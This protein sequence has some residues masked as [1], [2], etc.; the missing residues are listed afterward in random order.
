MWPSQPLARRW[1]RDICLKPML[2]DLWNRV[3]LAEL[4]TALPASVST[5]NWLFAIN[6]GLSGLFRFQVCISA[7]VLVQGQAP[8]LKRLKP[9]LHFPG[10]R[11]KGQVAWAKL[12][13]RVLHCTSLPFALAWFAVCC[14]EGKMEI[15]QQNKTQ[16]PCFLVWFCL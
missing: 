6:A 14:I 12:H 13:A 10:T 11:A 3:R 16:S 2:K 7:W 1:S 15:K 5:S 4:V 9:N 8:G